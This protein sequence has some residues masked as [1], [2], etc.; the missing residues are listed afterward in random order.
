MDTLCQVTIQHVPT[1]KSVTFD[2]SGEDPVKDF[3]DGPWKAPQ[4]RARALGMSDMQAMKEEDFK[5]ISI[6]VGK[7]S[8]PLK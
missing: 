3:T 7:K 4:P 5:L 8:L 2:Y 1:K 6:K